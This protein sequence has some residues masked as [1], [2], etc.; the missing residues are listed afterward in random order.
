MGDTVIRYGRKEYP[1]DI[2]LDSRFSKSD[3]RFAVALFYLAA[4]TKTSKNVCYQVVQLATGSEPEKV[5]D[6]AT[7]ADAKESLSGGDAVRLFFDFLGGDSHATARSAILRRLFGKLGHEM[8][9][10]T[11]GD[12]GVLLTLRVSAELRAVLDRMGNVMDCERET[13]FRRAIALLDVAI[14]AGEAGDTVAVVGPDGEVKK[15][16]KI[17]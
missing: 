17:S 15:H 13:V 2:P 1:L 12:G 8:P 3:I 6:D 10:D 7:F 11:S 4:D 14:R 9:E 5:L 16:I